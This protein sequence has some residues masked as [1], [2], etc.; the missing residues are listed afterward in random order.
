MS[1]VEIVSELSSLG[2]EIANCRELLHEKIAHFE[3]LSMDELLGKL[4][5]WQTQLAVVA[6]AL[7]DANNHKQERRDT[8]LRA[9]KSAKV[10]ELRKSEMAGEIDSLV[11]GRNSLAN[12]LL[13][14]GQ[15]IEE[16]RVFSIT[17]RN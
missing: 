9:V 7:T 1:E 4:S 3:A 14:I 11:E 13:K 15:E 10:M 12:Q 6:Q 5:Y 16:V 2:N 17:G 8:L